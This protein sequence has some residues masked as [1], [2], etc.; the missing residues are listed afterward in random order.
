MPFINSKEFQQRTVLNEQ[1]LV[2][3]NA[4]AH[5]YAFTWESFVLFS[6]LPVS[7]ITM[8]FTTKVTLTRIRGRS[9]E[10]DCLKRRKMKKKKVHAR[11]VTSGAQQAQCLLS[12]SSCRWPY[13]TVYLVCGRLLPA[14]VLEGVF[15]PN[16]AFF[17]VQLLSIGL[18][19]CF[20]NF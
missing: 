17:V 20:Q 5:A 4:R 2:R 3:W 18:S 8:R 14:L 10:I 6:Q 1:K 15:S 11:T 7:V 19:C 13:L 12:S 9:V 16:L